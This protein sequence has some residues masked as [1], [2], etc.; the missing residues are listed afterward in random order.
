MLINIWDNGY[1]FV[2]LRGQDKT[3]IF[4]GLHSKL[5]PFSENL[6]TDSPIASKAKKKENAY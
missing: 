1:F 4:P 3:Y 5:S 6:T 2:Y